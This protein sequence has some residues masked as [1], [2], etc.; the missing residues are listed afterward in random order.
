M[1]GRALLEQG[2][3]DEA[4]V[5]LTAAEDDFRVMDSVGHCAAAWLAQG[6]LAAR[7]GLLGDA[8]AVYRPAAEALQD[9][10]FKEVKRMKKLI[11]PS[12]VLGLVA[13]ASFVAKAKW[14]LGFHE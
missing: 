3:F 10:R 12:L 13:V 9:V 11:S 5:A 1:L 6:D 7:R 14:G 8:A 2:R 4:D